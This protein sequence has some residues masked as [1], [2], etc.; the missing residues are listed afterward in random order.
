MR[1]GFLAGYSNLCSAFVGQVAH[2]GCDDALTLPPKVVGEYHQGVEPVSQLALAGWRV[3]FD[4][5][6]V[7][8][9]L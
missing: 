7:G 8:Q 6:I 2:L 4:G 3:Q 9:L 1:E 5:N